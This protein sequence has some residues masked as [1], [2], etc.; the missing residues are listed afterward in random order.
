VQKLGP[1]QNPF[2][3]VWER[4]WEHVIPFL[5]FPEEI[6]RIVY[7]TN[8]V[9]SLHIQ[10][11]K[12]IKTRGHFPNDDA[13]IRLIWLAIQRAKDSWRGCYDWTQSIAVLRIHFGDRIPDNA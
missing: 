13:A 9:E 4:A 3:S 7:T 10:I 2:D 6:R 1:M 11:R 5:V 12:T 8:T